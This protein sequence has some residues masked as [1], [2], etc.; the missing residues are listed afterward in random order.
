MGEK[1]TVY[2]Y[3]ND[4]VKVGPL[5]AQEFEARVASGEVRDTTLVHNEALTEWKPFAAYRE[6]A[7]SGFA[8]CAVSGKL[9]P[10]AEMAKYDDQYVSAEHKD[11]FFQRIKEGLGIG[12]GDDVRDPAELG[13][14]LYDHG[15]PITVGG[16]ISGAFEAWKSNF[17]MS[18]GA[19]LVFLVLS[20]VASNIPFV[21]FLSAVLFQPHILAGAQLVLLGRMRGEG[22]KMDVIFRP[23]TKQ[24]GAFALLGLI[25]IAIMLPLILVGIGVGVGIVLGTN[26]SRPEDVFENG[27]AVAALLALIFVLVAVALWISIRISLA[28]LLVADKGMGVTDALKLSWRATGMRFFTLLGG[29]IVLGI[30]ATLGLLGFVIGIV[31]TMP[32][33]YLGVVHAYDMAFGKRHA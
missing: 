24:F 18:V 25:Q 4:G 29:F 8:R 23:L 16:M 12:G 10:V 26:P 33:A 32:L 6:L 19:V 21:G 27:A 30:C 1:P 15:Y 2:H 7:K 31:F 22:T 13:K 17:W 14:R 9:R 20:G 11:E 28:S 5:T 3:A